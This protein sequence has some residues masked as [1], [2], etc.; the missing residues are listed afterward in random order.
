MNAPGKNFLKVIG[1]LYLVFSGLDILSIALLGT[2]DAAQLEAYK[3]SKD[4][5]YPITV[6][7]L[8]DL[9][10]IFMGIM[11]IVYCSTLEKAKVLMGIAIVDLVG[12]AIFL[13]VDFQWTSLIIGIPIPILYLIGAVKNKNVA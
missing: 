12:T 13:T 1:I 10:G 3:A 7:L 2:M 6:L 9:F 4:Y 5:H 11:G 8:N